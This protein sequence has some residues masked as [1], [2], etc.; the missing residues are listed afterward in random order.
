MS[1]H[2]ITCITKRGDHYNAHERISSVGGVNADNT[3]WSLTEDKAIK[4]IEDRTYEFYVSVNGKAV[5]VV[6]AT[7]NNRKY[8][9]TTADSYSPN[10]LLNLQ[11]CP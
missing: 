4:S 6:V 11:D 5:D 8:L 1:R 10:N 3:S 9:K 2:R 7:H